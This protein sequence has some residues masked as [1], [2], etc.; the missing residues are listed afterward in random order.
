MLDYFVASRDRDG[1]TIAITDDHGRAVR[2]LK[3][4]AEAGLN[5][6]VWDLLPEREARIDTL[7]DEWFAG[8]PPV[9][10]AGTYTVTLSV[11]AERQTEELRVTLAP[12]LARNRSH[13]R[14]TDDTAS[15]TPSVP[16]RLTRGPAR[17]R[18][19]TA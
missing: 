7:E 19:E 9:V 10:A 17:T 1:A 3:G 15:G 14:R 16:A 6:V 4:P 12:V 18:G 5:R 11:G 8:Q 2:E 13:L